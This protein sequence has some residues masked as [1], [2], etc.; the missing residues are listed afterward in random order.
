MVD[1]KLAGCTPSCRKIRTIAKTICATAER[2]TGHHGRGSLPVLV[3]CSPGIQVSS[4]MLPASPA[5]ARARRPPDNLHLLLTFVVD[6]CKMLVDPPRL[7]LAMLSTLRVNRCTLPHVDRA[8]IASAAL[9]HARGALWR[10]HKLRR[11]RAVRRRPRGAAQRCC[12][13]GWR[14]RWRCLPARADHTQRPW[15]THGQGCSL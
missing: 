15:A 1:N 13:R 2:P 12:V 10:V 7:F 9:L 4:D 3:H 8:S 6:N 11:L 14:A 5:I